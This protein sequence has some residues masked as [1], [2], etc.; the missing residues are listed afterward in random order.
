MAGP[1]Q[2]TYRFFIP[3]LL[4][5]L[6]SAQEKWN[7]SAEE[8]DQIKV[9]GQTIRRLKENVR[10]VKTNQIIITDNAVQYITD[11]ILYMNGNTIM[12]N[13][14]DTLTCD[15][16][17]YWSEMDSGYAMG[18]V[19]YVQPENSR[20]LTTEIFHY[21]QTE[22]YRGSSFIT[23]GYTRITEPDQLITANK[24]SYDDDKQTMKLTVN[25]SVENPTR[26]IF[27]DEIIIQYADS[28]I[29]EINV[30]TNA[31][32]YNDLTVRIKENGPYRK[33]RD[34]M[35]SREMIAHF[36]DNEI[37]QLE[38]IRMAT[39]FYHV[40]NDSLL[41]GNNEAS[42]DSIQIDFSNGN[43]RRIQVV[44][45]ALGEFA[46]ED[47]NTKID[48]QKIVDIL[49]VNGVRFSLEDGSWGLIRASSN[50]PS[51]VIV[52]ESPTSDKRK[53]KIF[54]FIDEMIQKTGKVGEYDQKI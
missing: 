36:N 2:I 24:I 9:D 17:V 21:W 54:E 34:K 30:T 5:S 11:D 15:S 18:K 42:G 39:T 40:I 44:G 27:G 13:G 25:A 41:A 7:Y 20:R 28:L 10:F 6:F 23:K 8:M 51:L 22:G 50:K 1:L 29:K 4:F 47:N 12:I 52:T 53:K 33:F 26:G 3:L 35:S 45:G 31:S 46:P 38:L 19:R 48:N 37:T 32:A 43:I 49:T 16:M 14:L